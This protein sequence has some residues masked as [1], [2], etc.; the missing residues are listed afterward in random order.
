M[1]ISLS[2]LLLWMLNGESAENVVNG[3]DVDDRAVKKS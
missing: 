1:M 2:Q 3:K